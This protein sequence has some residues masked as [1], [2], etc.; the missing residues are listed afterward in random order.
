MF[1]NFRLY[2]IVGADHID[3]ITEL[4]KEIEKASDTFVELHIIINPLYKILLN[5]N[6]PFDKE[7]E[8]SIPHKFIGGNKESQSVG[9]HDIY[10]YLANNEIKEIT[11]WIV[12]TRI[13][14]LDGF[15]LMYDSL[16]DDV[17]EGLYNEDLYPVPLSAEVIFFLYVKPMTAFYFDAL[18]NKNSVVLC[19]NSIEYYEM[20][21][22][23]DFDFY[24]DTVVYVYHHIS[25]ATSEI[26]GYENLVLFFKYKKEIDRKMHLEGFTMSD[27][28]LVYYLRKCMAIDILLN[29]DII[30]ELLE[31][32]QEFYNGLEMLRKNKF[33]FLN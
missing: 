27:M 18:E 26:V 4:E 13:N 8:K 19:G 2:R 32:Q 11:D 3:H 21:D 14:T 29:T 28:D 30:K 33:K 12:E 17:R 9:K 5:K 10:G 22:Y 20:F 24:I 16:S 31:K 25:Y 15:I 7:T 23:E 6:Y 1:P